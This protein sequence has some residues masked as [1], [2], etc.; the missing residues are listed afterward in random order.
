VIQVESNPLYSNRLA[1]TLK[2]DGTSCPDIRI[3]DSKG[4]P[5]DGFEVRQFPAICMDGGITTSF[6]RFDPSK[7]GTYILRIF[8]PITPGAYW[9]TV[10]QK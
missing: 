2:N 6:F 3:L 10:E 8:T 5:A 1:I 4:R 7:N 9:V